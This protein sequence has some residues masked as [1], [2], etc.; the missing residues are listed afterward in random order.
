MLLVKTSKKCF[1]KFT[2][3]GNRESTAG[4]GDAGTRSARSVDFA[5]YRVA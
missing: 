2:L 1:K 5:F 3:G 4:I